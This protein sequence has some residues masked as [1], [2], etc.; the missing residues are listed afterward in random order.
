VGGRGGLRAGL[1]DP[2]YVEAVLRRHFE[3]LLDVAFD[4]VLAEHYPEGVAFVVNGRPVEK[5]GVGEVDRASVEVRLPKKRKAAALGYVERFRWSSPRS[6]STPRTR[7]TPVPS[8]PG[9]R[10]ITSR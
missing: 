4:E 7:P 3:P 9:P 6:G 5:R 10:S 1:L 8:L 2:G